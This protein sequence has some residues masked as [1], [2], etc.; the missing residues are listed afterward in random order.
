MEILN[1][2]YLENTNYPR[3]MRL[4]N[5][6]GVLISKISWTGK[7][8]KPNQ[9]TYESFDLYSNG[10]HAMLAIIA[11]Y[12]HLEKAKTIEKLIYK[13]AK[14]GTEITDYI[15]QVSTGS[16][17]RP[18]QIIPWN[19]HAIYLIINE[20]ARWENKGRNPIIH[21]DLFAAVWLKI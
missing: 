8:T 12:Y 7:I 20:I 5:P 3:L 17:F 15:K 4:N 10:V 9:K 19:R 16:G 1:T 13:Y 21:P 11:N 18:R 6:G 14:P 2:S